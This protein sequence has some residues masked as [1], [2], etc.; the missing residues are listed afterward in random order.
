MA[1]T[2]PPQTAPELEA[3]LLTFEEFDR[4][5]AA[6]VFGE[7]KRVELLDG[8]LLKM[9]T[10]GG[11]HTGC[12]IRCDRQLQRVIDPTLLISVQNALRMGGRTEFMPDLAVYRGDENSNEIPRGEQVLLL[13]E[14]ADSSR[15]YDRA[16]KVPRYAAAGI[17]ETILVDLVEDRL[18]G[19]SEPREDGYRRIL[20]AGRGEQL[21]STSL[22]GPIFDVDQLLG[23]KEERM[24]GAE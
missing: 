13:I 19:Y 15:N 14:V 17:P 3:S 8:V 10:V 12:I 20:L 24:Q 11:R 4:I 23:P 2:V 16:I 21:V 18:I 1:M 22:P 9:S 5:K 6:R 7:N